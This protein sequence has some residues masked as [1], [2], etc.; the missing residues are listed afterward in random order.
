MFSRKINTLVWNDGKTEQDIFLNTAADLEGFAFEYTTDLENAIEAISA[1]KHD[2]VIIDTNIP[3]E[4][5]SKLN[6]IIELI[7]PELATLDL[8]M[9][10]EAFIAFK[11]NTM[12]QKWEDAQTGGGFRFMD[13]LPLK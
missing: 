4:Q 11:L 13:D 7:D 3:K 1:R 8:H 6:K 10:D 2:L 9:N 5:Q 12:R